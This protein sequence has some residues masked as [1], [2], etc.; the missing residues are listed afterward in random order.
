[1]FQP[2]SDK[3]MNFKFKLFNYLHTLLNL[4]KD[5][6]SMKRLKGY[7][8][9]LVFLNGGLLLFLT[10]PANSQLQKKSNI[11]ST[12]VNSE[13]NSSLSNIFFSKGEKFNQIKFTE[14]GNKIK[15]KRELKK[16]NLK[17]FLYGELSKIE[18]QSISKPS[19]GL[20]LAAITSSTEMIEINIIFS[21][22]IDLSNLQ[23]KQSNNE[24]LVNYNQ[25]NPKV[26]N[27]S[28]IFKIK[29][30]FNNESKVSKQRATAPPLGDIA[31][32]TTIIPNPNLLNLEGPNIPLLIFKQ[33]PAKIAIERLLSKSNYSFVWVQKDPSYNTSNQ[34]NNSVSSIQQ[35]SPINPSS[36]AGVVNP[37]S[38][39]AL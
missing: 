6:S 8:F 36:Q 26:V 37:S 1:M 11:N 9:I 25:D 30:I 19:K 14:L 10:N 39:A 18:T 3:S 32:G 17:L 33:T 13:T 38:I 12:L 15:I 4:R 27:N 22:Y 2:T 20:E 31:T 24:L 23:I 35:G 34:I 29:K 28:D 7:L 5:L 16:N 21:E